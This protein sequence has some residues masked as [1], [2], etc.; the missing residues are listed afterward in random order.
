MYQGLFLA[1]PITLFGIS[2]FLWILFKIFR[3]HR[4]GLPTLL[5][6]IIT[7]LLLVPFHPFGIL[8]AIIPFILGYIP[9]RSTSIP[10]NPTDTFSPRRKVSPIEYNRIAEN[11]I[12]WMNY[13]ITSGRIANSFFANEYV[14]YPD[15]LSLLHQ[16]LGFG[17][18]R[19]AP[20]IALIM[21]CF[22][23]IIWPISI[24][25][26]ESPLYILLFMLSFPYGTVIGELVKYVKGHKKQKIKKQYNIEGDTYKPTF[27]SFISSF[28]YR[29][30]PAFSAAVFTYLLYDKA[31][32]LVIIG[33]VVTGLFC[34]YMAIQTIVVHIQKITLLEEGILF[35]G[36]GRPYG[37]RWSYFEKADIRERRNLISGTDRVVI[38]YT[39]KRER[40][41][42]NTSTLSKKDEKKVLSEIRKRIPTSTF[43]DKGT[44]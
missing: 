42:I 26:G 12:N 28:F 11:F 40:I 3:I 13:E 18:Y 43:F 41:P 19:K 5:S 37:F 2:L 36:F 6:I 34:L 39:K 38:L 32:I 15:K 7:F 21:S 24:Y 16:R 17:L 31:K 33:D 29:I 30:S 20:V 35:S 10:V 44:V 25:E 22:Y 1:V 9:G 23:L 14:P 8:I 4:P 27:R